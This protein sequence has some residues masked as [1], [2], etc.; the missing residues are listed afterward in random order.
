MNFIKRWF[1]KREPE[2]VEAEIVELEIVDEVCGPQSP[3]LIDAYEMEEAARQLS[4]MLGISENTAMR[5]IIDYGIQEGK[6]PPGTKPPKPLKL[7]LFCEKP[8]RHSNAFCSAECCK[9]YK[10]AKKAGTK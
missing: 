5:R 3:S 9:L 8:K 7:C 4:A 10:E 1:S 6:L 2:I